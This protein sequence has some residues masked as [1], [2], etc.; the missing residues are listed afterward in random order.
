MTSALTHDLGPFFP[1]LAQHDST[2]ALE[3]SSLYQELKEKIQ[4]VLES[5]DYAE[6]AP[7][8]EP[9]EK[10]RAVAWNIERG[11]HF[12]EILHLLSNHPRLAGADVYLLTECDLGMARSSN[13]SV[14]L[15]L[16]RALKLNYFFAP[17]YLNL[18]KGCGHEAEVD[19]DNTLAIHGNAILSRYPL[20]NLRTVPLPNGKD[21]MRGREKRIGNQR[22]LIADLQLGDRTLSTSCIHLDAHSSQ[23]HRVTQLQSVLDP[24][25][26]YPSDQPIL[27]GGDW[28]TST[29][30]SSRAVHAIIGFWVRVGM[31]VDNMIRNHYPHP[32]RYWEKDLFAMLEKRGFDY[33]GHNKPGI[34]TLHYDFSSIEQ[35]KNLREWIPEWCF[36]F[37]EW[38]LRNHDGR[39]SFK[40]D[41]FAAK[42]LRPQKAEVVDKLIV[43]NIKVSDHEAI[44]TE[45]SL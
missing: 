13:R 36:R 30:N 23:K 5:Y 21:K 7:P 18:S 39:L 38:S 1:H 43:N 14:A 16:A 26:E 11:T 17:S 37:I 34:G 44:L 15:D 3:S 20:K 12:D 8:A 45:F 31:G 24:L 32:D 33:K 40:L 28:N 19:D 10:Y 22:A 27:I 41:W 25:T 9:K 29:Y 2:D 6:F 35:Y 42:N 4:G